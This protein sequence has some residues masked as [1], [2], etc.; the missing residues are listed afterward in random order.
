MIRIA[1]IELRRT[2]A[3][4]LAVLMAAITWAALLPQTGYWDTQW[5]RFANY[6]ASGVFILLPIA[7]AGGALVGR[8]ERRTRADELLGSTARPRRQRIAP[9]VAATAV[10]VT[11]AH[12]FVFASG[13]VLVAR[14]TSYLSPNSILVPVTDSVILIGGAWL[15]FAAGRA[16]P[17]ALVPPS[18]AAAGLL[19]QLG[20]SLTEAPGEATRLDNLLLVGQPPSYDWETVTG[21]AILG[22]LALGAGF[23]V[24]G[25]LLAAARRWPARVLAVPVVIVAIVAAAEI[26]G[27]GQT[28]RYMVDHDAQRLVCRGPVCLTAVHQREMSAIAPQ[29]ERALTLLAKLPGAPTKAVEWRAATVYVPGDPDPAGVAAGP[30][31]VEFTLDQETGKPGPHLVDDIVWGAGVPPN[32]CRGTDDVALGAAGAW[33]LGAD[34]INTDDLLPAGVAHAEIRDTVQK[35]R[36]LPAAEQTRRVTAVRD[37]AAACHTGL[38]PILTAPLVTGKDHG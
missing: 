19:A 14:S 7:L 32:A 20:L 18:L 21:R 35:L 37:A 9:T 38:T 15:G 13:G 10:A 34:D 5:T 12:L 23:A 29:A 4:T 11:A 17:S 33:V 26:P 24:A 2:N 27:V 36:K 28:G 1:W 30:S 16:W 3:R 22:H 6:Q 8:R 25:Y 31:T